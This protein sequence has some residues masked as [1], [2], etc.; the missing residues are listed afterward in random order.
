MKVKL[1]KKVRKMPAIEER[2]GDFRVMSYV[3]YGPNTMSGFYYSGWCL[4]KKIAFEIYRKSM[5]ATAKSIYKP[6][7]IKLR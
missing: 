4:T 6:A 5:V 3:D 1:L 2:N 7:K